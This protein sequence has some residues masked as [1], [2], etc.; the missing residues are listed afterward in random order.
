[1]SEHHA[2]PAVASKVAAVTLGFWILK[3][4]ATTLGETGGDWLTMTLGLGYGLGVLVLGGVLAATLAGQL[5]ARRFHRGLYWSVILATSTAGTAMSDFMDRTLGLGY[6]RGAL[7]LAGA[8]MAVLGLWF[9]VERNVSVD[10]IRSRRTEVFYWSAILVGN[11]LGTALGDYLA[12]GLGLGFAA[13][14]S[15]T[16]AVIAAAALAWRFTAASPVLLFW[17][18]FVATRPFGATFGDLLTKP[19]GEGGLEL[20]TGGA[21]VVLATLLVVGLCVQAT[22]ERRRLSAPNARSRRGR[23]DGTGL[24]GSG[25]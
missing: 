5:A 6:L 10:M 17:V 7:L 11:T 8:L 9:A 23:A 25:R 3:I 13:G 18:A 1:M 24:V 19:R 22:A 15:L 20:G 16:G 12:D 14:A 2:R 21:S 4:L